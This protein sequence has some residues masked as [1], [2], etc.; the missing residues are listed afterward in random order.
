MWFLGI[1]SKP[2]PVT[3]RVIQ[4]TDPLFGWARPGIPAGLPRY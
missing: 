1:T 2:Y 3:S 4:L